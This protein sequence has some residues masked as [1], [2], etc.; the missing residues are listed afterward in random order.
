MKYSN[1]EVR[2]FIEEEDVRFI[3]LAFCDI[4]GKQKNIS[5]MPTELARA[6]EYGVAIDASAICGFGGEVFS[7][8][9]L[10]PVADTLT[11]LPWRSEHGKVVRMFCDVRN[12]DGTIFAN[13]SRNILKRAVEDAA[14]EGYSF[15]FGSELEFYLFRLDEDGNP[16]SIP[17]D[18]AGYMDIAPDDRGENVRRE[19]CLTLAEMGVWPEASHHEEGPGQNEI[20]FRYS[21]ALLAAD[22]AVTFKGVV[23]AVA[24]KNGLHADFSPKPITGRPGSG[25][26]MNISVKSENGADPMPHVIAGI[27]SHISEITLF[28]NP[29]ESSYDRLGKDKAPRYIS[30]SGQNRSQLIRIPASNHDVTRAE[31]RSPDPGANPYL[32]YTLLIYAA[33]DGIKNKMPLQES[34]DLNLFTADDETL[35]RFE[36]L[37]QNLSEAAARAADSAFIAGHLP[38]MM[39]RAYCSG[40]SG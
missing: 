14:R 24:Q 29:T 8:L 36:A 11:V 15:F 40:I 16:T 18:S 30:W 25:F 4:Y 38:E 6:F 34:A 23:K 28:L 5:I 19:I 39:I 10:F 3:R 1:D 17:F 26:H 2:Q 13:D 21:D 31:L 33:L 27:L 7:D 32:A 12:P 35:R 37:P 20:D 22:N 9:F